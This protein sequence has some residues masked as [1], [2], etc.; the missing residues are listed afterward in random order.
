MALK[1][2]ILDLNDDNAKKLIDELGENNLKYINTNIM[3]EEPVKK[4]L[5]FIKT[6]FGALHVAVNCAVNWVRRKNYWQGGSSSA[7]PL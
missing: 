1:V 4:A 5:E 7:R 6:E 2:V 3:E